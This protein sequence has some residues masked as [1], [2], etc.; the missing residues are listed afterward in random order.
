MRVS[1]REVSVNERISILRV[2]RY[3]TTGQ[4]NGF[5]DNSIIMC[6]NLFVVSLNGMRL[7]DSLTLRFM[8]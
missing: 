2:Y 5:W 6:K 8:E 4:R 1:L 3:T 7:F